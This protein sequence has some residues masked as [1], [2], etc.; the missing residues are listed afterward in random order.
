[1]LMHNRVTD[2]SFRTRGGAAITA[3]KIGSFV[4]SIID[5]SQVGESGDLKSVFI[6]AK[7]V[8]GSFGAGLPQL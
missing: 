4:S 1:M 7:C 8:V 5:R 6:G 2:K 3:R